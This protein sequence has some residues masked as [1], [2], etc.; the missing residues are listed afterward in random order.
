MSQLDILSSLIFGKFMNRRAVC[1]V[2][3]MGVL[4]RTSNIFKLLKL[5]FAK[6]DLMKLS[7]K[8]TEKFPSRL[9]HSIVFTPEVELHAMLKITF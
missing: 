5:Y 7:F 6:M 1:Y 9:I 4:P 3:E 8:K 2:S